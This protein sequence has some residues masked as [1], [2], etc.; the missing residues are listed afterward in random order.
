[1]IIH[2]L[3][4]GV[5]S[6]SIRTHDGWWPVS[7]FNVHR[8]MPR[9]RPGLSG[10]NSPAI[11]LLLQK[12][13]FPPPLR[14]P[15]PPPAPGTSAQLEA[16]PCVLSCVTTLAGAQNASRWLARGWRRRLQVRG[17]SHVCLV[18]L[19]L[20]VLGSWM[21]LGLPA[22]RATG[23]GEA[24]GASHGAAQEKCV[25]VG[26]WGLLPGGDPGLSASFPV[27]PVEPKRIPGAGRERGSP[28]Q[29]EHA[30]RTD[31]QPRRLPSLPGCPHR[32]HWPDQARPWE[33]RAPRLCFQ[34]HRNRDPLSSPDNF[35]L[36]QWVATKGISVWGAWG[37]SRVSHSALV[38][39]QHQGSPDRWKNVF[40]G[41]KVLYCHLSATWEAS[42]LLYNL[43]GCPQILRNQRGGCML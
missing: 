25:C 42:P 31:P 19:P 43:E 4:G 41:S 33:G 40:K 5:P 38:R 39:A 27:I 20:G 2:V 18:R 6:P 12:A 30:R 15:P 10:S 37:E 17:A 8:E 22:R 11:N 21:A 28:T 34:W 3:G 9:S 13:R 32:P 29:R 1:M 23:V 7:N 35:A 24:Q 36:S 14:P 26:G 16:P